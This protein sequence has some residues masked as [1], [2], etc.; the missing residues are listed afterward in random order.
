VVDQPDRASPTTIDEWNVGVL[1]LDSYLDRIMY[2]GPLDRGAETMAALHR[3]HTAAIPFENLDIILGRGV[4]VDLGAIQHKL[5]NRRRGGYCY[6][7]GLLFAAALQKLGFAV[8]RLLARVGD[9]LARPRP[10]THM[11]LAVTV[12]DERWLAD[13]G[14]GSGLLEPIPLT[15]MVP[16]AQGAWDYRLVQHHD[17]SADVWLMQERTAESGWTTRYSVADEHHHFSDVVMSNHYTSTW[18][19]SPFLAQPVIVRKDQKQVRRLLGRTLSRTRPGEPDE[20]FH[21]AD[22]E[23][24][25]TISSFGIDLDQ[26]ELAAFVAALAPRPAQ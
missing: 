13:V 25:S 18:P 23:L 22:D 10:R 26:A 21:V 17:G 19:Q 15:P 24:A 20:Q 11:A 1:D 5:V 8:A 6:E 16:S 4:S 2:D 7:H 9:D 14:F 3:A 12:S